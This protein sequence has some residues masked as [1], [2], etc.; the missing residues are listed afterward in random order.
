MRRSFTVFLAVSA[1]LIPHLAMAWGSAGHQVIAAGAYHELSPQ[2]QAQVFDVL[3]AHPEFSKWTNAYH[4]N[5]SFD[6]P[7]YVFM[8]SSTWPDEIRGKGGQY[9]HPNWHFVDYPLRPPGF[10]MEPGPSPTND[11]LAG[12]AQCETFLSDTNAS[13]EVRAVHLS[14][15]VHLVGD[16]H[17][18][19]HAASLFTDAYTNGDRGGNDF[20][21]KADKDGIRLHGLWDGLLG[22]A[23]NPRIQWNYAIELATKFPRSALPEL[24]SHLTPKEWSLES[25]TLAI[26]KGYLHGELKGATNALAAPELPADYTKTAKTVAEKQGALAGYRLADD[27]GK[28]LKWSKTVPLLPANTFTNTLNEAARKIGA[29]EAAKYYETTMVVTGKVAAVSLRPTVTIINLDQAG[30]S[31]PFTAVI[32]QQNMGAFGDVQKLQGQN[33]EISGTVTQYRNKPEIVLE[34]TNQLKVVD[35]K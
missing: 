29:M 12:I 26:E 5:A 19:L 11:V 17:Q 2:S 8:R 7:A 34:S 9:D 4:P 15:M 32:F 33:V 35:Q 21:V 31:S 18:P 23:M 3:Q 28:S 27:L 20:Y 1:L 6:L 22:G 16:L 10:P 24:K 30:P 14:W 13:P 25:R